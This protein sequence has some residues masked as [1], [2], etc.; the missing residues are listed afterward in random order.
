M[1]ID[2]QARGFELTESLR[3]HCERRLLFALGSAGSKVRGA[4]IRLSDQN[5]PRGGSD[6]RCTIRAILYGTPPAVIVQDGAD[7]Y[8]AINQA[9]NRL[10]RTI[11]RRTERTRSVRRT[12]ETTPMPIVSDDAES[13]SES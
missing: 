10:A 13:R 12:T 6:K 2:I 9:A 1:Q 7:L 3:D 8:V 11:S 5:G 4:S